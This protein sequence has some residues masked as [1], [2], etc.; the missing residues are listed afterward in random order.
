VVCRRHDTP[1]FVTTDPNLVA[2]EPV[3]GEDGG[4]VVSNSLVARTEWNQLDAS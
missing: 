3:K 4:I 1:E 2:L